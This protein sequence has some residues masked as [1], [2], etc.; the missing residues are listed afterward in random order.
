MDCKTAQEKIM[1]YIH[2]ELSDRETEDFIE[3]IRECETCSEEL[4][5]YFTIYYALEKLE[6]E[7]QGSFDIKELLQKDIEQAEQRIRNHQILG[8]YQR[9]FLA[10]MGLLLAV[11]LLTGVQTVVRGSFEKTTIYG[12]FGRESETVPMMPNTSNPATETQTEARE[13]ETNRKRQVIITTPETEP[14]TPNVLLGEQLPP[15]TEMPESAMPESMG[16]DQPV[17]QL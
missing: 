15:V 11:V 14:Q 1:P 8:F 5:V 3:H 9:L 16:T 13:P 10:V 12:L 17:T 4:E 6:D 2:R 7:G